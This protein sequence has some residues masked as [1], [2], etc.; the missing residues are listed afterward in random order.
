MG[1]STAVVPV[2]AGQVARQE[3]GS[4]QLEVRGETA[5]AMMAAQAEALVKARFTVALRNRRDWDD[6]RA[7]LLRACERP[8]FAG[9][10]TEKASWGAAWYRKPVGDGVEGFSVRFA[11]EAARCMGNVDVEPVTVYED[12]QKRV[13]RVSVL[14]L[15]SNLAYHTSIVVEKTV[16]RRYLKKGEEALRVMVN[17]KGETTY[18]LPATDDEVFSKQQN[19]V[20]KATRTGVLR[21]LPGDIQFEC[22]ERILAIRR[23]EAAKDPDGFRKKV[24]DGFT[25]LNILPSAL[26][27]Y[28][29]H[30]VA[31]SSPAEL[32][33]LRDLWKA[34]EEGKTTW[35]EVIEAVR[36]TDGAEG[37]GA[38]AE[39]K[40]GLEGVTERVAATQAAASSSSS[41]ASASTNDQAPA[42]QQSRA[43][44]AS[45]PAR[46]G[47]LSE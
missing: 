26:K 27:E 37:A 21:L 6:V 9:S 28:L 40:K 32:T 38:Q 29:G 10:A 47:R 13:L 3:L 20:S 11:E 15:E 45:K 23:G 7:R 42:A 43:P 1:G 36:Q 18:L 2:Q 5:T 33:D 17:S 41:T 19:L 35:S 25:K 4:S 34:I 16:V 8:G 22:R 44:V 46:Q 24:V 12:D 30:D 14:D 31:S 39:Q